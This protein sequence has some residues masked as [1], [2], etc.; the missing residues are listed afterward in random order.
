MK[1]FKEKLVG[2]LF[3]IASISFVLV[4]VF[5]LIIP[6]VVGFIAIWVFGLTFFPALFI[7]LPDDEDKGFIDFARNV[8]WR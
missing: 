5:W 7:G 2:V 3:F 8:G 4:I 1:S 6:S